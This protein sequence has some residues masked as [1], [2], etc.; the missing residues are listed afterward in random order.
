MIAASQPGQVTDPEAWEV[1]WGKRTQTMLHPSWMQNQDMVDAEMAEARY[2]DIGGNAYGAYLAADDIQL[3]LRHRGLMP[4]PRR[5]VDSAD[6]D[7]GF[8]IP[9]LGLSFGYRNT[10]G[11]FSHRQPPRNPRQQPPVGTVRQAGHNVGPGYA[12]HQGETGGVVTP[13][14]LD[15]GFDKETGLWAE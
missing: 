10:D 5:G 14:Y 6:V 1:E 4:D 7:T 15:Y 11:G 9:G 12:N 8:T 2:S 13:A 3:N